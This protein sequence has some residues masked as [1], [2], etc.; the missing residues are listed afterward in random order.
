MLQP[1]LLLQELR[2]SD[3]QGVRLQL[4]PQ[5]KAAHTES[6]RL[7]ASR[8]FHP[9]FARRLQLWRWKRCTPIRGEWMLQLAKTRNCDA[10]RVQSNP[11]PSDP[12]PLDCAD[13]E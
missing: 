7:P 12:L 13:S 10:W 2:R 5:K 3:M 8:L 4:K 6:L 11:T 9:R 1:L